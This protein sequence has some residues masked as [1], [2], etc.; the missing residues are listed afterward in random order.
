MASLSVGGARLRFNNLLVVIKQT[1]FEE[2]SQVRT[3]T[4]HLH[5]AIVTLL[6]RKP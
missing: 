4:L 1:A 5:Y 6:P 3:S 2:Y